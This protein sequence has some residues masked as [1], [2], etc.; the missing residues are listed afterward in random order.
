M[1]TKGLGLLPYDTTLCQ[2]PS[3]KTMRC[4]LNVVLVTSKAVL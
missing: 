1:M 2:P 4:A 3:V